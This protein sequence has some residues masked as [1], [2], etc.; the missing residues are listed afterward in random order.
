MNRPINIFVSIRCSISGGDILTPWA[1]INRHPLSQSH[2]LHRNIDE[3]FSNSEFSQRVRIV[4]LL[5]GLLSDHLGV[6]LICRYHQPFLPTSV[7]AFHHL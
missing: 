6:G 2:Q 7:K 3:A 5:T 1:D 4:Y